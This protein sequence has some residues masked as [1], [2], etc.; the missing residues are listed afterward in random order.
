MATG[1]VCTAPYLFT[2][3]ARLQAEQFLRCLFLPLALAILSGANAAIK[4]RLERLQ[5]KEARIL[6]G[7]NASN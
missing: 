7:G 6:R 3:C 4:K 1:R 2:D 5:L